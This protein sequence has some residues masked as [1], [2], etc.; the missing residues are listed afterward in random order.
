MRKILLATN[1]AETSITIDDVVFVVNGGKAKE[2]TYDTVNNLAC[3]LPVWTS[4]A[5]ARQRRGRAGRVQAGKCFHL[6]TR[7]QH[8]TMEEFQLPEL[9]RTPLA[10]IV[11]QIKALRLGR[12]KDFLSRAPQPPED[13]AVDNAIDLLRVIGALDRHEE[14]TPLGKH[15][16]ALPVDPRVGKMLVMGA[17]MGCLTL[18]ATIAAGLAHRD[19]FVMPLEK[20]EMADEEKR[21]F[22]DGQFSDHIAVLNAFEAWQRSGRSREFCFRHF[23]SH[24]T[25][26]MMEEM[27][28]QFIDL[29]SDIGFVDRSLSRDL[30]RRGLIGGALDAHSN[31]LD[32]LRAVICAGLFPSVCAIRQKKRRA[33]LKTKEDGKVELHPASVL[34][35]EAQFPEGWLVYNEKVMTTGIY[36]RDAS[37]VPD[38]ALLMFGGELED[39]GP[40]AIG[41]LRTSDEGDTYI[42]FSSSDEEVSL[43]RGLRQCLD[44]LLMMKIEQPASN[45]AEEGRTLV[46]AVHTLLRS[47]SQQ[48]NDAMMPSFNNVQDN[49]G[50]RPRGFGGA[51]GHARRRR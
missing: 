4:R 46:G 3:L 10:E 33:E 32:V 43:I 8:G 44:D 1:I 2:K 36:L 40:S 7:P 9:L 14:L 45:V 41:M 30:R 31:D 15:L 28:D 27:R 34:S 51:G 26:Q 22:G 42:R 23:L 17:I 25:L 38:Y 19:P 47:N 50:D 29:L 21:R 39:A 48:I 5:S 13:R 37:H 12:A 49:R 35:K 20:K 24:N 16:A 18:T 11:M 6:F